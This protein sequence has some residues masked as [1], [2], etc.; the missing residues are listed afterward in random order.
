MVGC[1]LSHW[2]AE[3]HVE[4][5]TADLRQSR[6]CRGIHAN[7]QHPRGKNQ[8]G[9]PTPESSAARRSTKTGLLHTKKAAAKL[10]HVV[11]G[12]SKLRGM[13]ATFGSLFRAIRE[14]ETGAISLRCTAWYGWLSHGPRT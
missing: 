7:N 6:P 4:Q 8:I 1:T 5:R 2:L 10:N 3:F 9:T 12:A 14:W 13:V 11:N